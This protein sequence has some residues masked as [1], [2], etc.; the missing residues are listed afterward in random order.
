[1]AT[2]AKV[3][4]S[5]TGTNDKELTVSEGEDVTVIENDKDGFT[6]VKTKTGA[7]G[8]VPT[9]SIAKEKKE[10]TQSMRMN[11]GIMC[12]KAIYGTPS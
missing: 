3:I 6:K 8:L 1:V 4:S 11:M 5:Y 2:K 12:V 9:S 7:V 10:R